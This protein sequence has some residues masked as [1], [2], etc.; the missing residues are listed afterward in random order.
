MFCNRCGAE[1]ADGSRFCSACGAPQSPGTPRAPQKTQAIM[2]LN[3][4]KFD[5]VKLAIDTGFLDSHFTS[6]NTT[7]CCTYMSG[8]TAQALWIVTPYPKPLLH[9]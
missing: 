8:D 2:E 9:I 3:G 1:I 7:F 6:T 4:V 5:A